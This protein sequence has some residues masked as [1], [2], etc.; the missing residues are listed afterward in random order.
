MQCVGGGE[1]WAGRP[2]APRG[3]AWRVL[4]KGGG[5]RP[6]L[7]RGESPHGGDPSAQGRDGGDS[8]G[9]CHAPSHPRGPHPPAWGAETLLWVE[10]VLWSRFASPPEDWGG[11]AEPT[12]PSFRQLPACVLPPPRAPFAL[13]LPRGGCQLAPSSGPVIAGTIF[14]RAEDT[15]A[16][17]EERNTSAEKLLDQ[18]EARAMHISLP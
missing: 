1:R 5:E 18:E 14:E 9:R 2:L 11:G 13:S 6:C 10:R 3:C 17:N 16:V 8:R 12:L 7:A 15:E 4:E